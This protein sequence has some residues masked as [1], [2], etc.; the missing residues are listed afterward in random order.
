MKT[1]AKAPLAMAIAALFASSYALA[2]DS[3]SNNTFDTDSYVN[4]YWNNEIDVEIEH[5][6]EFEADIEVKDEF[7]IKDPNNYAAATVDRKQLSNDNTVK[8]DKSN[9]DAIVNGDSGNGASGNI[10]INVSA[11]D[12]NKQANDTSIAKG[13][14]SDSSNGEELTVETAMG[15]R[16]GGDHDGGHDGGHDSDAAMVFAKAATF[17]LQSSSENRYYNDGTE[18]N[19]TLDNSLQG[20]SGNIG[21]NVAAGAGNSQSNGLALAVGSNSSADATSGGVQMSYD[22][23]SDNDLYEVEFRGHTVWVQNNENNAQLSGGA[24]AGAT[25]NIGANIASGNGNMQS[26]TLSIARSQ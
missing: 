20:A 14:E 10:G 13:T 17:S 2:S 18:N 4:S 7:G 11:G 5:E 25:G 8:A 9:N 6:I 12:L 22:N 23:M 19:A 24:L 26:N 1:F 16:R 21:V 15:S 3:G